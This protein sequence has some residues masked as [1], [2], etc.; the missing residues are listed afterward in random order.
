MSSAKIGILTVSDRASRGEYEDR[1]GPAIRE[2]LGDVLSSE[3]EPVARI[4]TDDQ[5]LIEET[6]VELAGPLA[7]CVGG[8]GALI[9]SG[10][11]HDHVPVALGSFK[12][13]RLEGHKQRKEWSTLLLLS[14]IHI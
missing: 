10:L 4:V 1:G 7:R 8:Q 13:F 11:L 6:L 9:L 12:K 14:L 5:P 3:W 2:Y